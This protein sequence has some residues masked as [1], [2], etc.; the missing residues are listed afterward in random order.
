MR[1]NARDGMLTVRSRVCYNGSTM[2]QSEPPPPLADPPKGAL[3][4]IF[5]IVFMDLLGF[6]IIL[7]QLPFYAL[8]YQATALEVTIL[9]SIYSACQFV[10]APILGGM[11]DRHGRR[12]VLV[13][14]QVGSATGYL[15]LGVVTQLE[16]HSAAL[17]LW[18][19][20]LSRAI[21]G[22]SGGNISTAQAYISD[23]TT[24]EN[25]AK[26][27]GVIGA[28]FGVGFAVGP[29]MGGIMGAYHV[30]LPAYASAV[31]C[32]VASG[33]TY[34]YLPESLSR[35]RPPRG[36]PPIV[37]RETETR[38]DEMPLMAVEPEAAPEPHDTGRP[39]V[40]PRGAL[41][42]VL[43]RP[44]L[45]QLLI[46]SFVSMAAFVMMDSSIALFLNRPETFGYGSWEI[47]W[48]FAFLG[49]V[50]AVVQ[51][52]LIGRLTA[53]MG[54]WSLAILGPLLVAGGMLCYMRLGW[55]PML[56]ILLLG[57]FFNAA[58]RS[59]QQPTVTSLVSKLSDPREQGAVF[60]VY[61]GLSGLARVIG[62]I[63]AGLVY[64]AH[65]VGPFATS[66]ALLAL[67]GV[68]TIGLRIAAKP[69]RT[70]GAATATT[71]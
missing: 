8:K 15:L 48:F 44:L 40:A 32:V 39:G 64:T 71:R 3:S 35:L 52:G 28:A 21:D 47:G 30:S 63:V 37:K 67:M 4:I 55:Q 70:Q 18:L 36:L 43:R 42:N 33:L 17:A 51:G 1:E 6:G 16:W 56:W 61:H 12:P 49:V 19:I 65:P 9:F 66:A 10:A 53:W 25:R 24:T 58:G 59:L 20:Y 23:V 69:I 27:M 62:P 57:G 5:L 2:P 22:F 14:S 68:W 11:S 13:V 50:I 41:R 54:E 31:F 29:A 34:L 60:G 38:I 7:P 26:G 45:V 46:V